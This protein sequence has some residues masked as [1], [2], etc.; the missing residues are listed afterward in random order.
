MIILLTVSMQLTGRISKPFKSTF[1]I[2]Q[3]GILIVSL[4]CVNV[5]FGYV[6][7]NTINYP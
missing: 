5:I 3:E 1:E 2:L 6:H 7:I 4:F